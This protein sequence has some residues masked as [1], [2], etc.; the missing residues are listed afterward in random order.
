MILFFSEYVYGVKGNISTSYFLKFGTIGVIFW[1]FAGFP[2][3]FLIRTLSEKGP[4]S[5]KYWT[6]GSF[7][8]MFLVD[9][10]EL[11]KAI[12]L[13]SWIVYEKKMK[14]LVWDGNIMLT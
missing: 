4:T 13:N 12:G 8:L 9:L 2:Y 14:K 6:K 1:H 5:T 11:K 3:I 10:I 7:F